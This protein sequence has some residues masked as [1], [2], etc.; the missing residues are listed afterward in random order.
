MSKGVVLVAMSNSD[1]LELDGG[2]TAPIGNYLNET[3]VPVMA[4]INA[5]YQIIVATPTG[6]RAALDKQSCIAAHFGGS[7]EKL[8]K[9]LDF[10]ENDPAIRSPRSLRSVVEGG[11]DKYAALFV[12]GGHA[13]IVDL[14]DNPDLGKILRDFHGHSK[15]TALICHGPIATVAAMPK[16]VEFRAAM[17][18]GDL[19]KAQSAASGWQYAGYKMTIF[20]NIEEKVIEEQMFHAKMKFHVGDALQAGGGILTSNQTPFDPN[21]VQDRE[22][23]TGQNPRSDQGVGEAL[24]KA[25]ERGA[26]NAPLA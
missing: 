1:K 21:V 10:F 11:L 13:P 4:V 9:A 8:K 7:E 25:L 3:V 6:A 23:I 24:V 22:L 5:G 18:A 16:A 12:P 26:V 17:E 19:K 14:M 2:A 20:S 15:P